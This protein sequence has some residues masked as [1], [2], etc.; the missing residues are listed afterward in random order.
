M[1]ITAKIGN[2]NN[3]VGS[4]SQGNKV[5]VTRVQLPAA[6]RASQLTD[7]DLSNVQQGSLLQYNATRRVFETTT[8]ISGAA[9]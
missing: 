2:T 7:F 1:S 8:A 3:I 9:F 6:T 5:Q 4:V